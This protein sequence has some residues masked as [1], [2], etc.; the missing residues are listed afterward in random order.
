[1]IGQHVPVGETIISVFDDEK[2]VCRGAGCLICVSET[3]CQGRGRL[4]TSNLRVTT[5]QTTLA[6]TEP[7]AQG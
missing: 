4:I 3:A 5:W 1:M 6:R 2:E 7:P